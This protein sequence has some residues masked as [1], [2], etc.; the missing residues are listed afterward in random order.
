[1]IF[2]VFNLNN[3]FPQFSFK[4]ALGFLLDVL[5][6][7]IPCGGFPPQ[8]VVICTILG[9]VTAEGLC[10][11]LGIQNGFFNDTLFLRDWS[12]HQILFGGVSIQ[13]KP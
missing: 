10:D 13:C 12:V 6:A 3:F 4:T 11:T 8:N 5:E 7:N 9:Q 1:M 2:L